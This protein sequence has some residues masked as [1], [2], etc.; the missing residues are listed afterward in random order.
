M[1]IEY[2]LETKDRFD[3]EAQ[4]LLD[5]LEARFGTPEVKQLTNESCVRVVLPCDHGTL[6][7]AGIGRTVAAAAQRLLD[8]TKWVEPPQRLRDE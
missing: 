7:F 6:P 2:N 1:F 4:V 3:R 8:L 5:E